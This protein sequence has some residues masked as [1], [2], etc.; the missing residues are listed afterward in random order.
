MKRQPDGLKEVLRYAR[1][2]V[3]GK[4]D[5]GEE[6]VLAC[7]RFLDDYNKSKTYIIKPEEPEAAIRIIES[8][9][10]YREGR[11]PITGAAYNSRPFRLQPWQKFHV[12]NLLGIYARKSGAPKYRESFTMVPRKNGKTPFVAALAWAMALLRAKAG[13]SVYVVAASLNQAMETFTFLEWNVRRLDPKSKTFRIKNNAQEHSI[14][15]NIGSGFI[16]IRVLAYNPDH[17]DSFKATVTILDELHAF[18]GPDAYFRMQEA[19]LA[20][21]A[22]GLTMAITTAGDNQNSFCYRRQELCVRILKGEAKK[23]SQFAFIARADM[24]PE[25]GLIDYTNPVQIKKANPSIGVTI[26]MDVLLEEAMS[27][28]EDADKRRAFFSRNLDR[29]TSSAKAYFDIDKVR[30]SDRRFNWTIEEL[31]KLPIRWY[32]GADLS[33]LRDLTAAG[34]WGTLKDYRDK[35]G[36]IIDVDIFIPH[37]WFPRPM[38]EEKASKEDIPVFGWEEDGWLTM[39][40]EPTINSDDVAKWFRT[41]RRKGFRIAEVGYDSRFSH[42]FVVAM[43]NSNFKIVDQ[44]QYYWSMS[45]GFRKIEYRIANRTFYY[46]HAEPFEYC[47]GNVRAV[48][49]TNGQMIFTKVDAGSD[50]NGGIQRIDV[51]SAAAIAAIRQD[52][53]L[54]K[55]AKENR[56][57]E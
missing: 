56:W 53:N 20:E 34:L 35:D 14:S 33:K 25:T 19:N 12:Y 22:Q 24:D 3:K 4:I 28:T 30:I 11:D 39:V 10:C 15:A 51:F 17:M 50:G 9:L 54:E 13:A 52:E 36:K 31:A 40:N 29:Y 49:R 6:I 1:D 48:E 23:D 8:T 37:C 27:A 47:I 44:P 43:K 16:Y 45:S 42:E 21:G 41:M 57:K 2:V 5:A 7:K 55:T 38:A 18:K 46:V 26:S 32:G